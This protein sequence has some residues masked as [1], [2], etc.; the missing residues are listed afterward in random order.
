MRCRVLLGRKE[1]NPF[2]I[3]YRVAFF[4]R[5]LAR[6]FDRLVADGTSAIQSS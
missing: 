5:R 4:G 3:A 2:E 6:E 1:I